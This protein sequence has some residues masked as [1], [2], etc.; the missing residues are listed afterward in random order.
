MNNIWY[1]NE[2]AIC[3]DKTVSTNNNF[4]GDTRSLMIKEAVIANHDYL[5]YID[6]SSEISIISAGLVKKKKI[7]TEKANLK[8]KTRDMIFECCAKTLPLETN[9]STFVSSGIPN[10]LS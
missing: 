10:N 7:K 9:S 1:S 5:C 4:P 3:K 2:S 6:Y 8:I